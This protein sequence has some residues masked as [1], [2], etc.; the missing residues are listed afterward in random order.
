MAEVVR[1][2]RKGGK[3]Y[4]EF[5]FPHGMD[6]FQFYSEAKDHYREDDLLIFMGDDCPMDVTFQEDIIHEPDFREWLMTIDRIIKEG[7]KKHVQD[8]ESR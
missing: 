1:M 2:G 8:I 7:G 5:S 4:L 6:A 3:E